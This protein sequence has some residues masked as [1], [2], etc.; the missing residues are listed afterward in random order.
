MMLF[1]TSVLRHPTARSLHAAWLELEDCK[2]GI[3][4]SVADQLAP[5]SAGAIGSRANLAGA[6]LDYHG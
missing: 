4:P 1:H 6:L 5:T 2:V 3:L